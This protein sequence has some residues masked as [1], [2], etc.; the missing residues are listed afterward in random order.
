MANTA[1]DLGEFQG[2]NFNK[3]NLLDVIIYQ[4]DYACCFVVVVVRKANFKTQ[5]KQL[6]LLLQKI[7]Q[8]GSVQHLLR[9]D[10]VQCNKFSTILLLLVICSIGRYRYI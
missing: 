1:A 2:L 4:E 10:L 5:K 7:C 6:W 8:S 9:L 3:Q